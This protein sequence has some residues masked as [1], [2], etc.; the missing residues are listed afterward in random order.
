MTDSDLMAGDVGGDLRASS[1]IAKAI[2]LG[3]VFGVGMAAHARTQ[4]DGPEY[5]G[6][7][8]LDHDDL[9]EAGIM[10]GSESWQVANDTARHWFHSCQQSRT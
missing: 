6:L 10:P 4:G 3:K 1:L 8:A 2:E 5:A 7:D 9:I